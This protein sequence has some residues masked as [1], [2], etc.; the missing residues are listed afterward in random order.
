VLDDV[1]EPAHGLDVEED[2][3]GT[4]IRLQLYQ[5]V[6]QQGSISDR[7]FEIAFLVPAWKPS[8]SPSVRQSMRP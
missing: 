7:M 6:R 5:W 1:G 2:D 8:C 4:L 3:H